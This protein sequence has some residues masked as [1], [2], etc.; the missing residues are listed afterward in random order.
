VGGD[1]EEC[2]VLSTRA[3]DFSRSLEC[4]RGHQSNERHGHRLIFSEDEKHFQYGGDDE[5][6]Q[7]VNYIDLNASPAY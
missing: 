2:R 3:G 7:W 5:A 4:Q 6:H 1:R